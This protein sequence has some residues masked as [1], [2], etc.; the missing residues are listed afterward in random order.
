MKLSLNVHGANVPDKPRLLD[1]LK[2]TAPSWVVIMD[3]LDLAREI[4]ALLPSCNV[5]FRAWPDDD[6]VNQH[7]PEVWV[8]I[9][10]ARL[11]GA[12]DL[13][14]YGGN[15]MGFSDK[16]LEWTAKVIEAAAK[17]GLKVV[18]GNWSAGTPE[19]SDWQK[20]MARKIIELANTHRQF[21]AIGLHE[22]CCGI[23]TSGILNPPAVHPLL[24]PRNIT[25]LNLWHLG[26][27]TFL[28]RACQKMDIPLPRLV[29]TEFGFDDMSDVAAWRDSLVKTDG[30][31][32]IRGW[33]SCVNQWQQW[34]H[35]RTP[36]QALHEQYRYAEDVFYANPAIEGV[37]IFSWGASSPEWSQF[38]VSDAL[39]FQSLMI[40]PTT[41]PPI[42]KPGRY[43]ISETAKGM[44]V[45]DDAKENAP[46]QVTLQT[47]QRLTVLPGE[48][49]STQNY[50]W[51]QVDGVAIVT[52]DD[53][54]N[55]S[56]T[57]I[58]NF[59]GWSAATKS[60]TLKPD[61]EPVPTEPPPA[62]ILTTMEKEII[63]GLTAICQK[64][65]TLEQQN[66]DDW[67]AFKI[68]IQSA[69]DKVMKRPVERL[70][71]AGK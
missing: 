8:S 40:E 54:N 45:R 25:G 17:I 35:W 47:G 26:R 19:P 21:V 39:E 68:L 65:M 30:Y 31:R 66:I 52:V 57:Q 48:P 41:R 7:T 32:N 27:Y 23:V 46:I 15:E 56:N 37:C 51:F 13:W 58:K 61:I 49:R 24:W 50:D 20:P 70:L 67:P 64:Y 10:K 62:P 4:K 34:G 6:L 71:S 9:A 16:T 44:N 53:G 12:A 11:Q 29:V 59:H 1:Y 60:T 63:D 22:Y 2:K 28:V 3:N 55:V 18:V 38:D 33:K 5:V 43:I 42:P 14:C 36:Q 69:Q